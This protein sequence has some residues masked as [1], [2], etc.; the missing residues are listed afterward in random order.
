MVGFGQ[1]TFPFQWNGRDKACLGP[2]NI[3]L[4]L[5]IHLLNPQV[6]A[7]GS[8][9]VLHW[10]LGPSW[11]HGALEVKI[12]NNKLLFIGQPVCRLVGSLLTFLAFALA[13]L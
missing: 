6:F 8:H 12:Q 9:I 2:L 7:Q 11:L 1:H 4:Y 5:S 10:G 3:L 13:L